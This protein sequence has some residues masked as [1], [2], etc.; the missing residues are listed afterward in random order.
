[1]LTTA[2]MVKHRA[3]QHAQEKEGHTA[4][5]YPKNKLVRRRTAV[6]EGRAQ[7]TGLRKQ[8]FSHPFARRKKRNYH[9]LHGVVN[10]Y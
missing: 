5:Q 2:K 1:M 10:S 4:P 9:Q 7:G 3:T 6:V 8:P